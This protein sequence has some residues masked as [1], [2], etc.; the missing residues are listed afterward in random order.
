MCFPDC[1]NEKFIT[2][3]IKR[4][5]LLGKNCQQMS[6]N[7]LKI[8]NHQPL[9]RFFNRVSVCFALRRQKDTDCFVF[10]SGISLSLIT[11]HKD[12]GCFVFVFGISLSLIPLFGTQSVL[13]FI[14]VPTYAQAQVVWYFAI[15]HNTTQR[16]GL[17]CFCFWY[18]AIAHTPTQTS[19]RKACLFFIFVPTYAQAQVVW[20]FAIAHNTTQR[21]GLF[22]FC[23]WY[24]AIAHTPTQTS[25]RKAC[26]FFIFVPTYAQAQVVWYFAIAHNN[27]RN[28]AQ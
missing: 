3:L 13:I 12:T 4:S 24:F 6:K 26:L 17:F 1:F 9:W 2:A 23:F 28:S 8:K 22:C 19:A 20:Y 10:V 27:S 7:L 5:N 18:F 14:F 25:A 15:A 21:H 11:P 16:H